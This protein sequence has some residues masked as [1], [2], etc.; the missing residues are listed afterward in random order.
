MLEIM[1]ALIAGRSVIIMDE[2]TAALGDAERKNLFRIIAELRRNGTA[3]VYI[4]HNLEEVLQICDRVSVMRNGRLVETRGSRDWTKSSLLEAMLGYQPQRSPRNSGEG[5]TAPPVLRVSHLQ[6]ARNAPELSFDLQEGE[7][8]GIAGLVGSGRTEILEAIAGVRPA[9]KGRISV[10]GHEKPAPKSVRAAL[11]DGIVLAPE[12]RKRSGLVLSLSGHENILVTNAR[13][14]QRLGFVLRA[15]AATMSAAASSAVGISSGRLNAATGILSGG[16]QQKL[17]VGKWLPTRP[18]V[19]LLDEPTRGI[20]IGA[21]VEIFH[22]IRR[23]CKEGMSAIVVSSEF[24][25]LIDNCDRVV[26]LAAG[27]I[28]GVLSGAKISESRI[29]NLI[30]AKDS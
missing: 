11:A 7:I 27:T 30:F 6:V 17:V 1:R 16:N 13:R 9:S 22:T 21:K 24:E 10:K 28:R 2:P 12:D 18:V 15:A 3:I 20:D 4:A 26:V 5:A 19:L 25:E 14:A 29:L 8:L 23:L